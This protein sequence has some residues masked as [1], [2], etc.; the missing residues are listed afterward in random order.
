MEISHLWWHRSRLSRAR[1][2]I[3]CSICWIRSSSFLFPSLAFLGAKH[4]TGL[5]I[6][7]GTWDPMLSWPRYMLTPVKHLL[8]YAKL[9]WMIH[10]LYIYIYYR[11]HFTCSSL[12]HLSSEIFWND[13][14]GLPSIYIHW[15]P[16]LKLISERA[17][18]LRGPP[19]VNCSVEKKGYLGGPSWSIFVKK[20]FVNVL[21][22]Y[23]IIIISVVVVVVVLVV[24]VVV[25]H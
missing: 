17:H 24:V 10:Y 12:N 7:Q 23:Y 6:W 18:F 20:T 15:C 13:Q 2:L 19:D 5:P 11:T 25:V 14:Q 16:R 4:A 21:I 3:S 8:S 22:Y 1:L 9:L